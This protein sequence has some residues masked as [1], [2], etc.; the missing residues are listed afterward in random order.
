MS[1]FTKYDEPETFEVIEK[2]TYLAICHSVVDVG[3]QQ[4]VDGSAS[5][6]YFGFEVPSERIQYVKDGL[7]FDTPLTIWRGYENSLAEDSILREQMQTWSGR[8]ACEFNTEVQNDE[9]DIFDRVGK[10]CLLTILHNS[11]SNVPQ[12]LI[13]NI[14]DVNGELLHPKQEM[15][16]VKFSPREMSQLKDLPPWLVEQFN[17]RARYDRVIS[18][19]KKHPLYKN[20]DHFTDDDLPF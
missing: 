7:I 19:L 11:P 14:S 8:S 12:P 6:V 20:Q 17:D 3:E 16:S 18:V 2:G 4:T 1:R 15:K 13:I 10:F 9:F 5:A